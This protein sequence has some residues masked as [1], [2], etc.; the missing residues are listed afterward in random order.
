MSNVEILKSWGFSEKFA[1]CIELEGAL[2]AIDKLAIS[3]DG[4]IAYNIS[5]F[6][7][8]LINLGSEPYMEFT[9]PNLKILSNLKEKLIISTNFIFKAFQPNVEMNQYST[10][11]RSMVEVVLELD[12]FNSSY[13][14]LDLNCNDLE[15]DYYDLDEGCMVD[16]ELQDSIT[17]KDLI[18][19]E[20]MQERFLYFVRQ[21]LDNP[22]HHMDLLGKNNTQ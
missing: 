11:L 12:P 20:M 16:I 14:V 18:N 5:E 1:E 7:D 21:T 17:N 2:G 19:H 8:H 3:D 9:P 6:S 15:L 10:C 13:K 4:P 22:S